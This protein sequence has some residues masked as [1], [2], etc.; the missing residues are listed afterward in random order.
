MRKLIGYILVLSWDCNFLSLW[1]VHQMVDSYRNQ[2]AEEQIWILETG[3]LGPAWGLGVGLKGLWGWGSLLCSTPPAI[4]WGRIGKLISRPQGRGPF[5]H[6]WPPTQ[7]LQTNGFTW[8]DHYL[9]GCKGGWTQHKWH[10]P[11]ERETMDDVTV[12]CLRVARENTDEQ[13]SVVCCPGRRP[14]PG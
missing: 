10:F 3:R 2:G 9:L 11:V 5:E 13:G 7:N 6:G 1:P 14:Q 4:L 12:L 8:C